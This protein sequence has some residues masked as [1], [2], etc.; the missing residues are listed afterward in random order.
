MEWIL[1]LFVHGGVLSNKDS[2][3]I[4]NVPGFAVQAECE[5]AGRVSEKLTTGTTKSMRF[6][7]VQRKRA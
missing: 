6:V 2:M 1:I 3:G 7:C 4:T 5:A